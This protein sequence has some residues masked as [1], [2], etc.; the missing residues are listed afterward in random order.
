MRG[1]RHGRCF[2][3][4]RRASHDRSAALWGEATRTGTKH[5]PTKSSPGFWHSGEGPEPRWFF[6]S[7]RADRSSTPGTSMHIGVECEIALDFPE[8]ASVVLML[9][10]HPSVVPSVHGV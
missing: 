10:L 1:E 8:P 4:S 5:S 6:I 9:A 3:S 7:P 2:T